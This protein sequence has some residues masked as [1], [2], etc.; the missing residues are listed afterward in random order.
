MN[1]SDTPWTAAIIKRFTELA[2]DHSI[3]FTSIAAMLNAEFTLEL[4]RNACIGKARRLGLEARPNKNHKT[5]PRRERKRM[6]RID[7]PIPPLPEPQAPEP[8]TTTIYQLTPY[9]CRW[10]GGDIHARPPFFYCGEPAIDFEP[11][12]DHHMLMA[13]GRLR[14]PA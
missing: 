14:V 3:S 9:T 6:V 5:Y 12:C 7:A 1:Q 2:A 11:Y 13:H 8:F 10:P 4:T